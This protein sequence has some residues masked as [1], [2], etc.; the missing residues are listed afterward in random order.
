MPLSSGRHCHDQ[1]MTHQ[2][3]DPRSNRDSIYL[4][5][6]RWDELLTAPEKL[7]IK[8]H[9]DEWWLS[10]VT[11]GKLVNVGCRNLLPLGIWTA[12]L[13]GLEHYQERHADSRPGRTATLVREPDNEYDPFAV[14]V[15]A[16]GVKVGYVP[17]AMARRVA[18]QLDA[19]VEL[20]AIFIAGAR[21]PVAARR[22]R[23]VIA[24]PDVLAV[25]RHAPS[26]RSPRA[27]GTPQATPRSEPSNS[28]WSRVKR[29]LLG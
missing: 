16:D 23:V 13:R 22:V 12:Q 18:K 19:D 17:K 3:R 21:S 4:H 1:P 29:A 10:E 20:A 5:S 26:Q 2:A 25:I 27:P 24:T 8:P 7:V 6:S 28:L 15:Y 9:G 11:T 14:A